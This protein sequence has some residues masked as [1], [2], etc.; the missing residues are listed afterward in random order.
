MRG[1]L[2]MILAITLCICLQ[3][4]VCRAQEHIPLKNQKAKESYALGYEFGSNL[5]RQE[6]EVDVDTLISAIRDGLNGKKSALS[7]DETRDV[8]GELRRKVMAKQSARIHEQAEKNLEEGRKFLEENK[9]KEGVKTLPDGLQY[10]ILR[11][12]NGPIPKETDMVTV[13]YR[14]TLIDG[15]EFDSSYKRGQAAAIPVTGVIKGWRK[16]LQLMKTGS[17][18]QLFV[19][20]DLAYGRRQFGRIPPNSTL[21][22]EL[23]LLSIA[24]GP[25]EKQVDPKLGIN[26]EA[27]EDRDPD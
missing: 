23:E 1:I 6:I 8:M 10:K 2:G 5:K 22:F 18:W 9:T 21:I 26:S 13:N 27:Q 4:P 7:P 19:P 3:S 14:G 15:T 20:A 11:E 16:A 24:E 17:K 25:I 12:G